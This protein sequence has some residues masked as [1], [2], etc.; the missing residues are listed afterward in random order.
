MFL[1]P[2]NPSQRSNRCGMTL[3]ELLLASLIM[4]L[5]AAAISALAM[6]VQQNTQHDERIG[7]VTQHARVALQR[8]ERTVNESTANEHFPGCVAFGEPIQGSN[9]PDTLV[10]WRG[11][12][13]VADP[14]GMPR[15]N[16]LVIYCPDLEQPNRLLEITV[17]SDGSL[18]PMLSDTSGWR[19]RLYAIKVSQWA[20]KTELT[21]QLRT[22]PISTMGE[23]RGVVRFDVALRPSEKAWTDYR[24]GSVAWEDLKWVQGIHGKQTGLRQTWCRCELQ[25]SIGD[26]SSDKIEIPF[27]GSASRYFVLER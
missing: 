15:F 21:D 11:D 13:S 1:R 23:R 10:V 12:V 17:P 26:D 18:A 2:T 20:N 16:E 19:M 22:V 14:N 6:A 8:I 24:S 7:T 5:F 25:L 9:V 3:L 27:I 4:A